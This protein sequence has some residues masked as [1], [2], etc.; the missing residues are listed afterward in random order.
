[1]VR[2]PGYRRIAAPAPI[3]LPFF[4]ATTTMPTSPPSQRMT[5]ASSLSSPTLWNTRAATHPKQQNRRQQNCCPTFCTTTPNGPRG[6]PTTV[7]RSTTTSPTSSLAFS[8]TERSPEIKL[9]RTTI[10][11]LN[12]LTSAHRIRSETNN[13]TA[14]SFSFGDD[15]RRE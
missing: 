12:F 10:F 9:V 14:F 15:D 3:R 4:P 5:R 7:A 8:P 2:A 1:M 6:S 11:L 13:G